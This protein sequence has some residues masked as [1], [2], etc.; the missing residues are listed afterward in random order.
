MGTA[1]L[2]NLFQVCGGMYNYKIGLEGT[3]MGVLNGSSVHSDVVF[4]VDSSAA[5][6]GVFPNLLNTYILP[7][8]E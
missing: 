3:N 5:L 1:P 6:S 7:C 8:I 2:R 4:V